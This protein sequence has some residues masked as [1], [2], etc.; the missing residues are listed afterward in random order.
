MSGH[1]YKQIEL[2][3]SSEVSSDDAIKRAIE[4]A[5]STLRNL[6]WFEVTEV[7]GHIKD[8]KVAHWQVGLKLGIRLEEGDAG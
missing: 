8:G 7:R 2:V 4:R 1:V 6:D 3:G 5:S